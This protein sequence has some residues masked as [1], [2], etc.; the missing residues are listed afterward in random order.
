MGLVTDLAINHSHYRDLTVQDLL[1]RL[2][3][4]LNAGTANLFFDN[5]NRPY[6][7]ASWSFLPDELHNS[8]LTNK[9]TL[10]FDAA[11]FFS[12]TRGDNLWFFDFL[13]PFSSPLNLLNTLKNALS[14]CGSAYL[15]PNTSSC[16]V[17][18]LW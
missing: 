16:S 10:S 13:C 6:A 14:N 3:P 1:G 8:I 5:T 11:Q 2:S 17:R 15:Y 7:L 9:A 18:R 12:T 4:A